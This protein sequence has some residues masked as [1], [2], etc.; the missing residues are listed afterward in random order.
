[1]P[2]LKSNRVFKICRE[3]LIGD[4]STGTQPLFQFLED[5]TLGMIVV[6]I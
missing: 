4:M 3:L 6:F 5:T 2:Q 1:M